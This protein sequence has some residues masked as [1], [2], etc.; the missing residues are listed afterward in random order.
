M[1]AIKQVSICSTAHMKSLGGYLDKSNERH[2][3][4][5]MDSQ[6]LNDPANW[7]REFDRTREAHGHNV[8]GKAGAKCTYCYHQIIGFNPSECDLNGGKL[9]PDDC[10]RFAREWV[11]RY[12]PDSEACWAL[13]KEHCAADG[14]D[15]YAVH[16]AI[17]RTL[18][19]GSGKRLDEGR[20]SRQKA[21]HASRM[22]DMDRRWGLAQ[23]EKGARNSA[24]HA[25]QQSRGEQRA[26]EAGLARSPRFETDLDHVR[27][28]VRESVREV[29]KGD[30]PNKMRA[31]NGALEKRGV[32]MRLSRDESLK[33]RDVVFEYRPTY[34][35][36]GKGG[37]RV[38]KA[39]ISGRKLGRG[40]SL[41]GIQRGLG[42][43]GKWLAM[44]AVRAAEES[45]DDGRDGGMF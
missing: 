34:E 24:H 17:N 41:T 37:E 36:R 15:R 31:L 22:R 35:R 19:D 18:L 27:R 3:V 7:E 5:D 30:E 33:S 12:Y 16:L 43:A 26:R 29:A 14:T 42:I 45:M 6:H 25:R 28:V 40:Y 11:E 1:T 38:R 21:L 9:S 4:L 13:H 20:A 8:A 39:S 44:E 10:M 2:E 32:H 23:M